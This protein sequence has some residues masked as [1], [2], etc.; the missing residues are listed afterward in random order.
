MERPSHSSAPENQLLGSAT[1]TSG[2]QVEGPLK[3]TMSPGSGS[4]NQ[5]GTLLTRTRSP[6]QPVQP[7]RVCS[8]DPEGMKKAC[9]RKVLTSRASTKAINSR[10]GSSR[11]S[12]P[13]F[14][15][16]ADRCRDARVPGAGC[17]PSAREPCGSSGSGTTSAGPTGRALLTGPGAGPCGPRRGEAGATGPGCP[18]TGSA[19]DRLAL[20]LDLGGLAAELAQVVQLGPADVAA[21]DDLDPLDDRGVHREGALHS[22]AEADLADG[23]GLADPTALAPDHDALEDLDAGA[24]ALDHADVHLHGVAGTELGDVGAQRVGVECVQGVHRGSP[25]FWQWLVVGADSGGLRPSIPGAAACVGEHAPARADGCSSSLL[26]HNISR[27][28]AAGPSRGR[29]AAAAAR[30]RARE[31]R[32]PRRW[33]R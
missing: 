25:Q 33:P 12:E 14:L 26:C 7:C 31:G 22:D 3:T 13:F 9:T 18:R 27:R 10:T 15:G 1:W 2:V 19:D 8:I 6:V 17:A 30:P 32:T 29:P 4:P 11:S 28:C 20:L 21:G 5:Y 23:E 24:V 16:G